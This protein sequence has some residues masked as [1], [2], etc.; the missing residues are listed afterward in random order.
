MRAPGDVLIWGTPTGE[1]RARNARGWYQQLNAWWTAHKAAREQTRLTALY[2][3]W[4]AR[5]ET[6]RPHRAEA[7]AQGALT[8]AIMLYGLSH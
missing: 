5:H 7:A 3:R 1:G 4:D 8:A 2:A 6:V